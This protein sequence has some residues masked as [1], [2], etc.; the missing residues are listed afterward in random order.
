MTII[1]AAKRPYFH[2]R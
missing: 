2:L 1:C